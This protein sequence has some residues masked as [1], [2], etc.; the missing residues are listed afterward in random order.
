MW[1]MY[2]YI[3]ICTYTLGSSPSPVR[4]ARGSGFVLF[5]DVELKLHC[6]KLALK[7]VIQVPVN[8]YKFH[9]YNWLRRKV[10]GPPTVN[11]LQIIPGKK[12]MLSFLAKAPR[13]PTTHKTPM[14][15]KTNKHKSIFGVLVFS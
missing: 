5:R 12:N 9:L 13:Q 1:Y 8:W 7:K 11:L 4:G 2:V 3:Y 14:D 15:R 10:N 6:S